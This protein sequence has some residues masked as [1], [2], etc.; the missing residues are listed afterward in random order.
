MRSTGVYMAIA[1]Q[2]LPGLRLDVAREQPLAAML[3]RDNALGNCSAEGRLE[4]R[5]RFEQRHH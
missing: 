5:S 2:S 4:A 3:S 1:E